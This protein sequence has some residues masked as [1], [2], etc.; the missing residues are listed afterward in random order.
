MTSSS[1]QVKELLGTATTTETLTEALREVIR[2]PGRARALR[3]AA[4]PGGHG[5]RRSR[6]HAGRL[7]TGLIGDRTSLTRARSPASTTTTSLHR[8]TRS[9]FSGQH[10]HVRARR[11]RD[12]RSAHAPR[13][14]T[15]EICVRAA[16]AARG[17][18]CAEA[19]IDRAIEVQGELAATDGTAPRLPVTDLV[20]RGGGGAGRPHRPA[21]RPRLRPDRRGH[22]PAH[23]VGGAPGHRAMTHEGP[24]DAAGP[25]LHC[26]AA[27]A[28]T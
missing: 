14:S 8:V 17:C 10:R 7:A 9:M 22:R 26:A 24:A 20:D 5:P 15:Q 3:A 28:A 16:A 1:R 11:P 21:L 18:R 13:T 25:S 19:R 27:G 4:P 6:G 23:G 12:A 2:V